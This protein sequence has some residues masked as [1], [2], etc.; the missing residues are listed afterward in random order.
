MALLSIS[1]SFPSELNE[2]FH[3]FIKRWPEQRA[4]NSA[5]SCPCRQPAGPHT[6]SRTLMPCNLSCHC[7]NASLARGRSFRHTHLLVT[8]T[9]A[10]SWTGLG[11]NGEILS[12]G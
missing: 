10:V 4:G 6:S 1:R 3:A 9:R 12:N 11:G 7:Q 2:A 8:L 5:R